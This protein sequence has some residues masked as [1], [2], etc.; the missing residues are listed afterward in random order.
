MNEIPKLRDLLF[1]AV[2]PP[3]HASCMIEQGVER[4]VHRAKQSLRVVISDQA[5]VRFST[6]FR[7]SMMSVVAN[8]IMGRTAR[9]VKSPRRFKTTER[10]NA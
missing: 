9:G 2:Q 7:N 1:E 6:H 8:P 4:G 5:T 10:K 3:G